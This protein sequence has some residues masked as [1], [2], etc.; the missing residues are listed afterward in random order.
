VVI[1]RDQGKDTFGS[2]VIPER[3]LKKPQQGQVVA[4]G[5]QV[6]TVKVGDQVLFGR[7]STLEIEGLG[8]VINEQDILGVIEP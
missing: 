5:A 3:A 1:V 8:L 6:T 7:Y 4:I 2:I